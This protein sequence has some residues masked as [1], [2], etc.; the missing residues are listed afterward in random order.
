MAQTT[1]SDDEAVRIFVL[2]ADQAAAA[3]GKR[4]FLFG[5]FVFVHIKNGFCHS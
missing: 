5:A 4:L 3:R 2:F 1:V